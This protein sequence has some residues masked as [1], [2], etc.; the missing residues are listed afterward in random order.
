[1]GILS[2]TEIIGPIFLFILRTSILYDLIIIYFLALSSFII[3][4]QRD[5][6][7]TLIFTILGFMYLAYFE[8]LK[9]QRKK[10]HFFYNSQTL[11]ELRYYAIQSTLKLSLVFLPMIVVLGVITN[12]ILV[13]GINYLTVI[14]SFYV[15]NSLIPINIEKRKDSRIITFKDMLKSVVSCITL[16][17]SILRLFSLF[18]F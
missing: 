16:V 2:T 8:Y 13:Y 4:N 10:I 11:S 1:M 3:D 7:L 18:I 15:V 6:L 9:N 12:Q 17:I 5:Y 14:I